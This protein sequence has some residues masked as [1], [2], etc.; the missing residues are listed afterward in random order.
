MGEIVVMLNSIRSMAREVEICGY[1][2]FVDKDGEIQRKDIMKYLN[3]LSSTLYV[4][5]FKELSGKYK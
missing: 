2:A 5:M 3:R 1:N 4:M